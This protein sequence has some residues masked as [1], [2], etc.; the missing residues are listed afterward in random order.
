LIIQRE[1]LKSSTP[2]EIEKMKEYKKLKAREYR[3]Q[4]K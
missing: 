3:E 2:E 4:K 1:K